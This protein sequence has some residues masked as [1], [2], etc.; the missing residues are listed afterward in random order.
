MKKVLALLFVF[1]LVYGLQAQ[2]VQLSGRVADTLSNQS[3]A[4]TSIIVKVG[5]V[6]ITTSKADEHG[7]FILSMRAGQLADIV[8]TH[9]GY[10]EYKLSVQVK[11]TTNLGDI[12]L[13]PLSR[14]LEAIVVQ[15]RRPAVSFKV[16]RQVYKPSEFGNAV[17]GTAVDAIKNLPMISVNAL[18]EI[19]FRGSSSFL[20]LVNGKPTVGEPS[21]ILS[22]MPTSSIENIEII[23]SPS[24]AYD[25]DGKA[26]IINIVTKTGIED[27]LLLNTSA[28]YGLPPKTDF[29]NDRTPQRYGADVNVGYRKNKWDISGGINYLRNDIAG[30]REGDVYTIAGNV[31]TFFPSVGERSFKRYNYGGR[32]AAVFQAT[33]ANTL[34][35]GFSI[36]KKY[37]SRDANILYDNYRQNIQ[38]GEIFDRFTYYN[39]NTQE[40]EGVFTLANLDYEHLFSKRSNIVLSA[41]YERAALSGKTYNRN[42]SHPN[43]ADTIQYTYNPN[44]NPLNAYR[45]KVDYT[46]KIGSSSTLQTGYQF[47]YDTQDGNFLYLTKILGTSQ[48]ETD[49]EFTSRVQVK[50]NIHAAYLQYAGQAGK[51]GYSAGSRFESTL[52]DLHFSKNDEKKKMVFNNFFPSAQLRF[53]PVAFTTLKAG[54]NRR[55]KRTN[56]YELNPFPER[57]HSETL[58]QGD[59]ELMPE[60]IGPFEIGLEQQISKGSF[61]ATLYHQRTKDPIQRVNKVYND[62]ILNR[63]FTNAGKALQTGL[64]VNFNKT[65]THW[66]Q[67]IIGGNVYKYKIFGKIFNGTIDVNSSI[68]VYSI[69]TTQ[70]FTLP[71]NWSTQLS[72]NYLSERVTAQGKDSRFLSPNFLLKKTT[73]DKRW[74]FQ[75]QWLYMDMGINQSNRQRITT[76]GNNFYTTTNYIYEPDQFQLSVSYNLSRRNRKINLPVSEIGE[77][78]F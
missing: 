72:V 74:A 16:D 68:W 39:P 7:L 26:G 3:L 30:K 43:H 19:S 13:S 41:L 50:N 33:A 76:W 24:A 22:Q 49:P 73:N 64:E 12:Y 38:T 62:T 25:A 66:W 23:T 9:A 58:E 32:M 52:R 14:S 45:I 63:V 6:T 67:T 27:G 36:S 69:N 5:N 21:A 28:M 71:H 54:Y 8:F 34:S 15:G 77:K 11:Q 46:K 42:L 48:Y 2:Q 75:L 57:E 59:P 40:K 1:F 10:R 53:K 78:E 51:W 65:V 17:S 29:N 60:L 35:A 44:T 20:V 61:F 47:R 18:G 55:I 37:Q 70:T 31:K 4:L 56:N